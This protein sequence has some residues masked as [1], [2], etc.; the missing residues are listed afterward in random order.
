MHVLLG[1]ADIC[2]QMPLDTVERYCFLFFATPT[3]PG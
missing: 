1:C 3:F 2:E